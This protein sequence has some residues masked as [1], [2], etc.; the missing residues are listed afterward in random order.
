MVRSKGNRI[1]R[2]G[3]TSV[4]IT[5]STGVENVRFVIQYPECCKDNLIVGCLPATLIFMFCNQFTK[6]IAEDLLDNDLIKNIYIKIK[7][8]NKISSLI[9]TNHIGTTINNKYIRDRNVL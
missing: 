4:S 1:S 9:S 2:K 8:N 6:K 3:T 7:I 5:T